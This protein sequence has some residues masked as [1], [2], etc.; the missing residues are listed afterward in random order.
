M[1]KYEKSDICDLNE[2]IRCRLEFIREDMGPQTQEDEATIS[3]Q[4]EELRKNCRV[5]GKQW[6]N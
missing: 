3:A 5:S 1:I 2:I 6:K 4:L